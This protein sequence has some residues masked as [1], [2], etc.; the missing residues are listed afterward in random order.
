MRKRYK[1]NEICRITS[2]WA[3]SGKN[4]LYGYVV[5]V[6]HPVH[7]DSKFYFSTKKLAA[8]T[9]RL[10]KAEWDTRRQEFK[11]DIIGELRRIQTRNDATGSPQRNDDRSAGHQ[12]TPESLEKRILDKMIVTMREELRW[13]EG[14]RP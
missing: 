13:L 3:H 12:T 5:L 8:E 1:K 2:D 6:H 14:A 10:V 9:A 4:A 11:T 7:S